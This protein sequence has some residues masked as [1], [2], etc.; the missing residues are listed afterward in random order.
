MHDR[1]FTAPL[2]VIIR[3]WSYVEPH[4]DAVDTQGERL[5]SIA[6][7]NFRHIH[8]FEQ[9]VQVNAGFA[10]GYAIEHFRVEVDYLNTGVSH[11]RLKKIGCFTCADRNVLISLQALQRTTKKC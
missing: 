2:D 11:L 4:L 3:R 8:I 6:N 7:V 5:V 1:D 9:V 10:L